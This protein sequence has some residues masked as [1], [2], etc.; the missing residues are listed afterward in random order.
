VNTAFLYVDHQHTSKHCVKDGI[1]ASANTPVESQRLHTTTEQKWMERRVAGRHFSNGGCPPVCPVEPRS[2]KKISPT[3]A[4]MLTVNLKA[5][6]VTA[7]STKR[8][9]STESFLMKGV[10]NFL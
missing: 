10:I 2:L 7:D 4:G 1:V 5:S 3:C 6:N 8:A 9:F